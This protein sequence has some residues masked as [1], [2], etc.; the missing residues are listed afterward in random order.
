MSVMGKNQSK[1]AKMTS[2]HFLTV[3]K[4]GEKSVAVS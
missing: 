3:K 1:P 2:N 4:Y